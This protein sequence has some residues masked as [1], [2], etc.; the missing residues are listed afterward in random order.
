MQLWR[1]FLAVTA[2]TLGVSTTRADVV[3]DDFSV[4]NPGVVFNLAAPVGSTF[5]ATDSLA[6]GMTRSVLVTQTANVSSPLIGSQTQ[7]QL[8]FQSIPG[9][10]VANV[11]GFS[12]STTVNATANGVLT[13]S[14]ASP[15]SLT[16]NGINAI[17]F[18]AT[19]SDLF[20][21]YS[22]TLTGTAGS[23]TFTGV[24]PAANVSFP[25]TVT[26]AISTSLVA[27]LGDLS[28][29]TLTINQG[30]GT[31]QSADLAIADFRLVGTPPQQDPVVPAPPALFLML[32]A[33]PALGFRKVRAK[34]GLAA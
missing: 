10:T 27:S 13:Y 18:T 30:A 7:V 24:V 29:V 11:N 21:P 26:N 2:L 17:A 6:G 25:T 4:Q 15:L 33:L 22:L 3:I 14:Y 34:L 16:M 32:A 20:V 9:P 23:T 12:M 31:V 8:G 19:Q 5:S 28:S 1:T